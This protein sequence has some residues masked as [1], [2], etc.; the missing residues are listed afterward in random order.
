MRKLKECLRSILRETAVA[1]APNEEG[2]VTLCEPREK[3]GSPM[4]VQITQV[5]ATVTIVSLVK[6][7]QHPILDESRGQWRR[8]C[9]YILVNEVGGG[10]KVTMVELKTTLQENSEGLERVDIV[11]Q[12][13]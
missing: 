2:E 5:P 1:A 3:G 10:C 12:G 9:D 4:E 8:I 6:G 7:S 11:R 13:W